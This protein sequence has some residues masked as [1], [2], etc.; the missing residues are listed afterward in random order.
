MWGSMEFE[1]IQPL[2]GESVLQ[3][4]LDTKGEGLHHLGIDVKN[5]DE[6]VRKISEEGFKPLL[7]IETYNPSKEMWAKAGYFDTNKTGGVIME[8]MFRP[9]LADR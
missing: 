5:Y 7:E 3:D 8:L 4:F 9:W 6:V 2:E 1:L